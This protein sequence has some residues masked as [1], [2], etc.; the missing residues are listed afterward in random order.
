[1]ASLNHFGVCPALLGCA[2]AIST[3]A[4]NAWIGISREAGE[5]SAFCG[6]R[7]F[8]AFICPSVPYFSIIFRGAEKY[9]WAH[10]VLD[11]FARGGAYV[12]SSVSDGAVRVGILKNG[13][14]DIAS[15][16][17]IEVFPY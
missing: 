13:Y 4:E 16:N 9:H 14:L 8:G 7:S 5:P 17:I 11:I 1:M 3:L 10:E 6:P 2:A 15:E 12:C